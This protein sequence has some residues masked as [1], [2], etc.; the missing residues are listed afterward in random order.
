[1]QHHLLNQ[2]PEGVVLITDFGSDHPDIL[3]TRKARNIIDR[4][5]AEPQIV[6]RVFRKRFNRW[7]VH[8]P[9]LID[10]LEMESPLVEEDAA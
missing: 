9:S 2:Y 4:L 7:Y 6:Q 10:Y 8:V 3:S 1:M 5:A